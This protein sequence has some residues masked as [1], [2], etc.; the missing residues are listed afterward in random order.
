MRNRTILIYRRKDIL[1][2]EDFWFN[3]Q[4]AGSGRGDESDCP[5]QS[6][7]EPLQTIQA[8]EDFRENVGAILYGPHDNPMHDPEV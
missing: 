3:L 7:R 4:N 2:S 6:L 5:S 8:Y 1:V